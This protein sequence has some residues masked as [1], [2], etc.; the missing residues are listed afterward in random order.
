[1]KIQAEMLY[2]QSRVAQEPK[3]R[4]KPFGAMLRGA[5]G[6]CAWSRLEP[7]IAARFTATASDNQ[8]LQ[9]SGKMYWVYCSPIGAIIAKLIKRFSILPDTC[10][11]NADFTFDISIND[12]EIKKLRGY[13]LGANNGFVFTSTFND[14]PRLHEE[15]GGG[16]GMYLRL[17]V[18]RGALLFRDQ[19][20]FL[21]IK[22]W[23]L[24]LPWWLT[25]GKFDLLHRNIDNQRFQIIIRVTHPLF[26]TL[27][28]QRGE[29]AKLARHGPVN[30]CAS[31]RSLH[32]GIHAQNLSIPLNQKK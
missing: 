3:N 24:A 22:H 7:A 31:L 23:R 17:A 5:L 11:R 13:Q 1:M 28:Y 18:K 14:Q 27:F 16:I 25:V 4:V 26:G 8:P 30:S 9:F 2:G 6:E 32:K 20:Y 10:A 21:R 19:G 29:F 15:F 12:G